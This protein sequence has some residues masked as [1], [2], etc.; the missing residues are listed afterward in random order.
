VTVSGWRRCLGRCIAHCQDQYVEVRKSLDTT[1]RGWRACD[2]ESRPRH[3]PVLWLHR[4]TNSSWLGAAFTAENNCVRGCLAHS[5]HRRWHGLQKCV[6]SSGVVLEEG[7]LALSTGTRR[8]NKRD[9][10]TSINEIERRKNGNIKA[11]CHKIRSWTGRYLLCK[12][13]YLW[14]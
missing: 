7:V 14:L 11:R 1:V 8:S 2:R 9:L 13:N 4:T 6:V 5:C 10:S 12:R 3:L